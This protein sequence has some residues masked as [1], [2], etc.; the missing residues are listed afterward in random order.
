MRVSEEIY[1]RVTLSDVREEGR[2]PGTGGTRPGWAAL[3]SES[4]DGGE[5][6][7]SPVRNLVNRL[8]FRKR[9]K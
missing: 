4:I 8:T 2:S 7:M 9:Y 3:G 6:P 5:T 1:G